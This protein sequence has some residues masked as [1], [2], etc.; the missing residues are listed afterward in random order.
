MRKRNGHSLDVLAKLRRVWMTSNLKAEP[1]KELPAQ[2][3]PL[4][5]GVQHPARPGDNLR[6]AIVPAA[7][8]QRRGEASRAANQRG[9]PARPDDEF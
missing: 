7:R 1:P 3:P 5:E 8:A 6:R 9:D 2:A 4:H